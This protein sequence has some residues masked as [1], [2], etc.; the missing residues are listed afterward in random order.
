MT[1]VLS[2]ASFAA[3]LLPSFALAQGAAG[4]PVDGPAMPTPR[5]TQNDIVNGSYSEREIRRRGLEIFTTSFNVFDGF[6]DGPVDPADPLSPGGRPTAN[7]TWMRLNGLDSQSC[8][9]CHGVISNATV[10]PT[11]G[12]AGVGGIS[13][14]AFP[15]LTSM[16][17]GDVDGS[18]RA[19]V[20]GRMINPPFVYG[21]GGVELAGKEMTA[22]LQA[23]KAQA[24]ANPGSAVALV[25]KGIDFGSIV[26]D[27]QSGLFDTSNVEGIEED[28]VVRPFGRKGEF[29][30]VRAFDLGAL[31]FHQGMQPA[32]VVG[33]GV[34]ADG[35][36]VV[37]EVLA[38]E[39]SALHVFA[40]NLERPSQTGGNLPAVRAGAQV[41][42]SAGCATCH[43]PALETLSP[44]LG[45]A[46]P[47]VPT[48]PSANVFYSA[49]LVAG[50]AHFRSNGLGVTVPLYSDLK[51]HDMGPDLAET[52]GSPLDPF[53]ITPRLWGASDTAPYM[54]DGRAL[55][56]RAA[57]EM[58]GGEGQFAAVNFSNLGSLDQE[59][60]LH[61]LD[62]L[63]VPT[64][65]A[66]DISRPRRK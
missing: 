41:F 49:D 5:M 50:P 27:A 44:T 60:L 22:E 52:T 21:A 2:A 46:L 61:F 20:D 57:I 12:V 37:N 29:L 11:L 23:L 32:E 26:F 16:D 62:S 56:L 14:S 9:E 7:G 18:L 30:S 54:H 48:D 3:L 6:G 36:G 1:H 31:M 53:F 45:L 47:E 8:Q 64:R 66:A 43:V 35:D 59:A 15:G 28:L 40:V 13:A 19:E 65:P 34:D 39:V 17:V 63:R 55:T 33:S 4:G 42:E 58:H 25:A 38:G 51:R 24:Q 10:P